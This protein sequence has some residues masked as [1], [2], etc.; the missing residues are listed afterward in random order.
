M[1]NFKDF[2]LKQDGLMSS[3]SDYKKEY[4]NYKPKIGAK[5]NFA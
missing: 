2:D 5:K 4:K 3:N 1:G